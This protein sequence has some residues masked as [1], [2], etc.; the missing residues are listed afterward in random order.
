MRCAH[1]F[2]DANDYAKLILQAEGAPLLD[3][4]ISSANGYTKYTWLVEGHPGLP[5]RQRLPAGLEVLH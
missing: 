2:G 3:V 4:E 1:T 5:H